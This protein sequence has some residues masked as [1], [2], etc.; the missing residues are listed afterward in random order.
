MSKSTVIIE[1]RIN[2]FTRWGLESSEEYRRNEPNR[3]T[4]DEV[5]E[6]KKSLLGLGATYIKFESPRVNVVFVIGD[7][8]YGWAAGIIRKAIA[9]G[10]LA[11]KFKDTQDCRYAIVDQRGLYLPIC[12]YHME[13]G[14]LIYRAFP[15]ISN[16]FATFEDAEKKLNTIKDNQVKLGFSGEFFIKRITKKDIRHERVYIAWDYHIKADGSQTVLIEE[17]TP[18]IKNFFH[19]DEK[20]IPEIVQN[21]LAY[22]VKRIYIPSDRL[23]L[24]YLDHGISYV[25]GCC[26]ARKWLLND[27]KECAG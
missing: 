16:I 2:E 5:E 8:Q 23:T 3:L 7:I 26:I 17:E 22:G 10:E 15:V 9:E 27:K 6:I 12:P 25:V 19:L 13:N 20:E 18:E 1:P 4:E 24:E 14:V 21:L 11:E